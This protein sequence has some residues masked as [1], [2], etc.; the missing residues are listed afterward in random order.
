MFRSHGKEFGA[1]SLLETVDNITFSD[2]EKNGITTKIATTTNGTKIECDAL[3]I[4]HMMNEATSAQSEASANELNEATSA[5]SEA[6]V[7][8]LNEATS[9]QSEASAN[10]L[11]E[12]TTAQS[13]AYLII[14]VKHV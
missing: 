3:I 7:N 10:E 11:N 6:S 1:V 4:D 13:E 2:N 14:Q 5:Q 12:A 9:A 8:G